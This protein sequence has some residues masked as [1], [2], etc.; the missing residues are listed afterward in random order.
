MNAGGYLK[1]I[2][3]A[4]TSVTDQQ[5]EELIKAC[6]NIETINLKNTKLT[7]GKLQFDSESLEQKDI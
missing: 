3:L 5:L 7:N 6:P 4:N 2:N 1:N